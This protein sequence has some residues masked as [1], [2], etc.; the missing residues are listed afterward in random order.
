MAAR[1]RVWLQTPDHNYTDRK[2]VLI[3]RTNYQQYIVYEEVNT[4]FNHGNFVDS[5]CISIAPVA[6]LNK[7]PNYLLIFNENEIESRY[8]VLDYSF[9][10]GEPKGTNSKYRVTLKRDVIV[11]FRG[12]I[13][14]NPHRIRR[15]SLNS[16]VYS[17]IL[18]QPEGLVL[19]EIKTADIPIK[20]WDGDANWLTI[21]YDGSGDEASRTITFDWASGIISDYTLAQYQSDFTSSA[22]I[23]VSGT[24]TSN[25]REL[26]KVC[27]NKQVSEV[28]FRLNWPG[29]NYYINV[30]VRKKG[31]V[32]TINF[33]NMPSSP[34]QSDAISAAAA[35]YLLQNSRT[36]LLDNGQ[37]YVT[38]E[39][40]TGGGTSS[41][42]IATA[43]RSTQYASFRNKYDNRII[44]DT[45]S[46]QSRVVFSGEGSST[47]TEAMTQSYANAV[48]AI[49]SGTF[50]DIYISGAYYPPGWEW[51]GS[52]LPDGVVE[53][54]FTQGLGS[55]NLSLGT[56][57]SVQS[58][59]TFDAYLTALLANGKFILPNTI[60]L[61]EL[62]LYAVS[63]PFGSDVVVSVDG[64][65]YSIDRSSILS[66]GTAGFTSVGTTVK[67][68]QVLPYCPVGSLNSIRAGQAPSNTISLT[69]LPSG[70][71]VYMTDNANNKLYPALICSVASMDYRFNTDISSYLHSNLKIQSIVNKTRLV[72]HNHKSS[73]SFTPALNNG[74][75][76]TSF[77]YTLRPFNTIFRI[78]PVFNDGGL[79]GSNY[80][81]SRGLIWEGGFSMAQVTDAWVEYKLN[82]STYESMFNREI[83]NMEVSQLA[84]R[85]LENLN[86]STNYQNAQTSLNASQAK[87]MLGALSSGI[88]NAGKGNLLGFVGTGAGLLS[89]M[90]DVSAGQQIA[91][92]NLEQTR[93]SQIINDSLRAES[94]AYAKDNFTFTNQAI[95]AR[96]NTLAANTDYTI[97]NDYKAYIEVYS[98]SEAELQ[99]VQQYLEFNGMK[100][101]QIGSI[102]NYI[103]RPT[104]SYIES[105]MIFAEGLTP[106]IAN[107]INSEL[108]GGLY[109]QEGLFNA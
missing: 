60:K 103:L 84:A 71:I 62:N 22:F 33:V 57:Q 15:G 93:Q 74:W 88:T 1:K 51:L 11:D 41:A 59:S 75:T 21:F 36:Y 53:V 94:I 96:P 76:Q 86:M 27:Y 97:I 64:V 10:S 65:N 39:G 78:C 48:N 26:K 79:Y 45:N 101:D 8:F 82:N 81:D 30:T 44:V 66:I 68:I 19:N 34:S 9:V 106:V 52:F 18:V 6:V 107:A 47:I 85:N 17:P 63:I 35:S 55:I 90:I 91:D 43:N 104:R 100:I 3:D 37:I 99:Y 70:N 32:N 54:S 80:R 108:S 31:D 38:P 73:F 67:D 24:H 28:S 4:H 23:T 50:N 20:S 13:T 58:I 14:N 2:R 102:S 89:N 95:Q 77:S 105:T 40:G 7:L 16:T 98:C 25:I 12:A 109:V 56:N 42:T 72:S 49:L 46:I 92:R 61:D 87:G 5:A 29:V 83:E 69:G